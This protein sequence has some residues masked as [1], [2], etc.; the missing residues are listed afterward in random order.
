MYPCLTRIDPG[1]TISSKPIRITL[2]FVATACIALGSSGL[3]AQSLP[4]AVLY[5]QP[6]SSSGTLYHSSWM[7]PDG[8]DWDQWVWDSFILP[9]TQAISEIQW[10]GGF[11]PAYL[12]SGGPVIDFTAAIYPSIAAGTEP[13]VV[14][15]PLV[16]YQT[17]GDG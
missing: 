3:G 2:V 16:E 17:G 4:T 1:G 10:R 8:S 5:S 11:D 13:N 6:P 12:G 14:D 15:P 9:S 7:D